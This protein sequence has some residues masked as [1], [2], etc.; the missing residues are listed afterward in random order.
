MLHKERPVGLQR[1][2]VTRLPHVQIALGLPLGLHA[3]RDDVEVM[4]GGML[5][6]GSRSIAIGQTRCISLKWRMF[7]IL[8]ISKV[9]R[10]GELTIPVDI[11]DNI[12]IA[13]STSS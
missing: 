10:A 9:A 5:I 4:S 11:I 7:E 13:P 3:L 12:A 8:M 6:V 1:S 2:E